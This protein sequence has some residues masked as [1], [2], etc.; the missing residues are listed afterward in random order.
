MKYHNCYFSEQPVFLLVTV[1]WKQ[2]AKVNILLFHLIV[3]QPETSIQIERPCS[4]KIHSGCDCSQRQS[5]WFVFDR[6]LVLPE[7]LIDFEYI[8]QVGKSIPCLSFNVPIFVNPPT[9]C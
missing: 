5:Q 9:R 7:Y 1:E 3:D 6:E 2:P 8:T 4:S